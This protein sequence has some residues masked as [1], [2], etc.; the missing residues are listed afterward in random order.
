MILCIARRKWFPFIFPEFS[1]FAFFESHT[2]RI[3]NIFPGTGA[4]SIIYSRASCCVLKEIGFCSGHYGQSV[5]QA[6]R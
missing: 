3:L 1:L 4:I 6:S 2:L 5:S